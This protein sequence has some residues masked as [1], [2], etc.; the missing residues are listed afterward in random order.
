[1]AFKSRHETLPKTLN[2]LKSTKIAG[3]EKRPTISHFQVIHIFLPIMPQRTAA[4]STH[5]PIPQ[6]P[7]IQPSHTAS[8]RTT[9]SLPSTSR[10][11]FFAKFLVNSQEAEAGMQTRK[12]DELGKVVLPRELREAVNINTDDT[13]TIEVDD[14]GRVILEKIAG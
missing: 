3:S 12:V 6:I 14:S 2:A 5:R 1:M 10:F 7:I 9:P 13:V 4:H 11:M 8:S